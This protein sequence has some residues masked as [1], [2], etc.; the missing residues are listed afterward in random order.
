MP[1]HNMAYQK[2][3]RNLPAQ[4]LLFSEGGLPAK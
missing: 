2:K 1:D 4:A 3:E